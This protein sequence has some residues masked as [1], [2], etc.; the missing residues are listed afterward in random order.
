VRSFVD[1]TYRPGTQQRLD[2]IAVGGD[3]AHDDNAMR[4]GVKHATEMPR[5]PS[6]IVAG[7][8]AALE[9][10]ILCAIEKSPAQRFASLRDFRAELKRLL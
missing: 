7:F 1:C 9:A 4:A 10:V 2:A 5:R 3:T 6:E 8:P